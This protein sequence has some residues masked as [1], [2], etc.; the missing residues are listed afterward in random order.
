MVAQ[1]AA[2]GV[3]I[4]GG[5]SVPTLK[6]NSPLGAE[7]RAAWERWGSGHGP[8]FRSEDCHRAVSGL[9]GSA[10]SMASFMSAHARLRGAPTGEMVRAEG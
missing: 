9:S 8:H 3:G 7:S 5:N 10:S 6:S 2:R 4:K 1:A